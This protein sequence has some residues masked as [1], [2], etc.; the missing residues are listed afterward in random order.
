[1]RRD[2]LA[3]NVPPLM[4]VLFIISSIV[5]VA[6]AVLVVSQRVAIYSLLGLLVSFFGTAGI[7]YTLDAGFLAVSQVLI[8]AG[9]LAVLF[10]FVLMFASDAPPAVGPLV[11]VQARKVFDP[12]KVEQPQGREKPRFA[13]PSALAALIALCTLA[14]MYVAIMKLPA[15]FKTFG[16][17]PPSVEVARNTQPR[18]AAQPV[19]DAVVYGSTQ[20][21]SYTIFD[22]FPLAF[23]VVSLLI[24]AAILGAVLLTRAQARHTLP[25]QEPQGGDHA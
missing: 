8:Y 18:D 5:A 25:E 1:M 9:A 4:E 12:S 3:A 15:S 7:F 24:F 20:G 13:V 19:T 10:L 14:V 23:E 2:I 16:E 21:M 17:L 11:T 6:G 22:R